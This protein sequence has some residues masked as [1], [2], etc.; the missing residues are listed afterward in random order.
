[1]QYS[2]DLNSMAKNKLIDDALEARLLKQ[3][4]FSYKKLPSST[5]PLY[6]SV[7]NSNDGG[8]KSQQTKVCKATYDPFVEVTTSN[9]KT[10]FICKTT[11][12]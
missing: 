7:D 8:S 12:L 3:H 1:M 11:A 4:K 9:S 10:I 6:Q 5:I 2:E